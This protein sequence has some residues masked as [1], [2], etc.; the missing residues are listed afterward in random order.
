MFVGVLS[1]GVAGML[2][3]LIICNN[4]SALLF[5]VSDELLVEAH[6]DEVADTWWITVFFF[7]GFH[8]NKRFLII[9]GFAVVMLS[10]KFAESLEESSG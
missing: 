4:F 10:Q 7:I 9:A 6:K 1:F 2:R 8:S 3:F 5:L